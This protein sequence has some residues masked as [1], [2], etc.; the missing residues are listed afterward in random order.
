MKK[1][2]FML[3]AAIIS[4]AAL[5]QDPSVDSDSQ[6]PTRGGDF[7]CSG[8]FVNGTSATVTLCAADYEP[9][10]ALQ[11]HPTSFNVI[12]PSGI[13]Y[14]FSGSVS[15]E[16]IH[17]ADSLVIREVDA[18]GNTLAKLAKYVGVVSGGVNFTHLATTG[19]F[20]FDIYC[21]YGALNSSSG[22]AISISPQNQTQ[23]DYACATYLGVGTCN[24][25]KPLHVNGEMR[26]SSPSY[27][28]YCDLI[29]GAHIGFNSNSK[30]FYFNNKLYSTKGFYSY[31][32]NLTFGTDT[33]PRITILN[34]NGNVGIGV[35]NPTQKLDVNGKLLLRIVDSE[36]GWANSYLHWSA[37]SLVMG[38]PPGA[39]AHNSIDVKPGG[40]FEQDEPLYSRLRMYTA[41]FLNE[42]TQ[43]IELMTEGNCWF[44]NNGNFGIGTSAPTRKLDVVGGIRS[45]SLKTGISR[46]DSVFT[47]KIVVQATAGADFVFDKQYKLP[48]IDA[49]KAFIQ[50]NGHLPEIQSAE[51]MQKNG[52]N[53]S[54]FQIQLLQKIEELTLYIIKQDERIKEL[55]EKSNK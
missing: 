35:T 41:T 15:L 24:P 13:L 19:R 17:N 51:D 53:V 50:A 2:A 16:N 33:T 14:N 46:S 9:I 36:Q 44:L 54:D 6:E 49:V 37:H 21:Y 20:V 5:A 29:A 7:S 34:S 23:L 8:A 3:I 47:S 18:S 43:K 45:D 52:V 22:F 27:D 10:V 55:E 30:P 38:T 32:N 39:Y 48:S 26:V 42:Q 31:Y 25:A 28:S 40:A 4:L 11:E 1:L 12:L